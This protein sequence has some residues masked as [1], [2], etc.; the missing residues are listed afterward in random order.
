VAYGIGNWY[1]YNGNPAK[2]KEYFQRVM[3]GH[4]WVTWGFVGSEL[5]LARTK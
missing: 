2:A 3:K 5:E 4:V 1:L